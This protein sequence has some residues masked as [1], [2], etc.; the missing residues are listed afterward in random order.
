MYAFQ[1]NMNGSICA[2]NLSCN[3]INIFI[4]LLQLLM[5]KIIFDFKCNICE[6]KKH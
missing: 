4:F 6:N 2:V 3:K 1:K 5:W